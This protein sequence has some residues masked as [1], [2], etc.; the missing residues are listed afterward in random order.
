MSVSEKELSQ[1]EEG[2]M[3]LEE[4]LIHQESVDEHYQ[5]IQEAI[6]EWKL[7]NLEKPACPVT[8]S[9]TEDPIT[10]SQ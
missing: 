3:P 1:T 8:D 9:S 4:F 2:F 7:N 10:V 6:Q 5:K